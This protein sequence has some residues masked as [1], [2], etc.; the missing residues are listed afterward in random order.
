MV[1]LPQSSMDS[2]SK[3][4]KFVVLVADAGSHVKAEDAWTASAAAKESTPRKDVKVTF[5][6]G[7]S[8]TE[9]STNT[10]C[11]GSGQKRVITKRSNRSIRSK[12]KEEIGKAKSKG[13]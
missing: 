5:E 9:S 13:K 2:L 10:Y 8:E 4:H 3:P 1:P 12:T 7:V 6:E 11:A